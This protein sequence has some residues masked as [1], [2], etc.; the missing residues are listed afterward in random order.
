[1]I[2]QNLT[3]ETTILTKQGTEITLDQVI[4]AMKQILPEKFTI[5]HSSPFLS[6]NF[7]F[8]NSDKYMVIGGERYWISYSL[9]VRTMANNGLITRLTPIESYTQEYTI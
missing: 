6:D 2:P 9:L 5:D 1:M 3:P 7:G 4:I 8:L